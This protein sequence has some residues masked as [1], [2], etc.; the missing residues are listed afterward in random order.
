MISI[1]S[2]FFASEAQHRSSTHDNVYAYPYP[3]ESNNRIIFV[4]IYSV[5]ESLSTTV[6]QFERTSYIALICHIYEERR[7]RRRRTT[8][9]TTVLIFCRYKYKAT[10]RRR[11]EK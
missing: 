6:A 2:R 10:T 9:A 4:P 8:T 1:S 11:A 7:G 3:Q 5:L